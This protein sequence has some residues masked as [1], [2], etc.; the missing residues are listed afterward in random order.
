MQASDDLRGLPPQGVGGPEGSDFRTQDYSKLLADLPALTPEALKELTPEDAKSI[1]ANA[2]DL[3]MRLDQL[4]PEQRPAAAQYVARLQAAAYGARTGEHPLEMGQRVEAGQLTQTDVAT[5][6]ENAL[7]QNPEQ[8]TPDFFAQ[9]SNWFG[10]TDPMVQGMMILGLPLF[11]GGALMGGAGGGGLMALLA[12]VAGLGMMGSGLM[13]Q[14]QG[15]GGPAAGAAAAAIA[16]PS[17]ASLQ[18]LQQHAVFG[19][20][21]QDGQISGA[22]RNQ[23]F[24]NPQA[25]Q[26]LLQ[27]PKPQQQALLQAAL[28]GDSSFADDMQSAVNNRNSWM[29]GST[30]YDRFDDA[31]LNKQQANQLMD[32]YS[33]LPR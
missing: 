25:R 12:A 19:K 33:G 14:G 21:L 17:A 18:S 24:K 5:A 4:P 7:R 23:L 26:Q 1:S 3:A 15:Q 22:E 16:K 6:A 10:K 30:V 28:A 13:Q 11:L 2:A 31:G 29:F 9:F 32:L 27:L 20:P 8:A